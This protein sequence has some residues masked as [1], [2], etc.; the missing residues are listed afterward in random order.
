MATEKKSGRRKKRQ[1][2]VEGSTS[3]LLYL[4]RRTQCLLPH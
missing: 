2:E 1:S 3:A 4:L